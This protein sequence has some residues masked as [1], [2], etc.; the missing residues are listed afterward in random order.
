MDNPEVQATASDMSDAIEYEEKNL[1][2]LSA[3]IANIE[4]LT[5]NQ[6]RDIWESILKLREEAKNIK[7]ILAANRNIPIEKKDELKQRVS[8]LLTE[9]NDITRPIQEYLAEKADLYYGSML[10]QAGFPTTEW[11][12]A[13]KNITELKIAVVFYLLK[14]KK[15]NSDEGQRAYKNAENKSQV[16]V[17]QSRIDLSA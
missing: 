17:E 2:E 4:S 5:E 10:D 9:L 15:T 14:A 6:A 11:F 8:V 12:H 13:F 1:T 3:Q 16:E 7:D